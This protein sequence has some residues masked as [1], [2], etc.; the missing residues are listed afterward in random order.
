M[1]W[2][3]LCLWRRR[4]KSHPIKSYSTFRL[5][6]LS[7]INWGLARHVHSFLDFYLI[8][9]L[10]TKTNY[11]TSSHC[12]THKTKY[13]LE[14]RILNQLKNSNASSLHYF[15]HPFLAKSTCY[16]TALLICPQ[17]SILYT[18]L[19]HHVAFTN[20][21]NIS[22]LNTGIVT[23][24]MMI[25]AVWKIKKMTSRKTTGGL[26]SK[27]FLSLIIRYSLLFSYI[28]SFGALTKH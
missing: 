28:A 2:L 12:F 4:R 24:L 1:L 16:A 21:L 22:A 20:F 23:G 8:Q 13:V 6:R 7:D 27:F 14:L 25:C 26:N 18:F 5:A 3:L 19:N 11:S 9:K 10:I 17:V 15:P